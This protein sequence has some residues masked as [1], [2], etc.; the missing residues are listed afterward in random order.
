MNKQRKK[1]KKKKERTKKDKA[2]FLRKR[3]KD[4]AEK[5][6]ERDI[7]KRVRD[8]SPKREPFRNPLTPEKQAEH[9]EKVK[10]KLQHNLE[11]LQALEDEYDI[12]QAKREVLNKELEDEGNMTVQEKMKAINDKSI[13]EGQ[14]AE[15]EVIAEEVEA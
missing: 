9:D 15:A 8:A 2:S 12:E 3:T 11:V 13:A 14:K 5:R 7:E 6:K 1:D 10:A 4:R